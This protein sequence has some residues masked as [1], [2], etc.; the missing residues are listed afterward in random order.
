[1]TTPRPFGRR[2]AEIR[3]RVAERSL[4]DVF[5]DFGPGRGFTFALAVFA[6]AV[7]VNWLTH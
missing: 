4:F 7:V 6:L 2:R 1:M 5:D 3:V